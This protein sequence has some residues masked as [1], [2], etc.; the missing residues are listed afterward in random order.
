M[1]TYLVAFFLSAICALVLTPL[2]RDFAVA[3][4]AVDAGTEERKVHSV[5]TPRVGGIAI[6]VAFAVPVFGL[7]F[8][9]NDISKVYLADAPQ[10]IGLAGGALVMVLLGLVDDL[11]GVRPRT[12]LLV[13]VLVATGAYFLGYSIAKIAT[14]F[15][16]PIELGWLSYPVTV[17]WIVGIVN[18]I[19]LIDGLDGLATGI[20]LFTVAILF[21]LGVV[22]HNIIVSTTAI[23]LAGALVGFLRY[24][25]NPASI[26]MG[27]SGSLFLGY[28]LAVTAISGSSKSSTVVSLLIP[29]LAMGVPVMDTLLAIIR[30]FLAGRHLFEA[31]RGHVHHRLLDRG[32]SQRQA[33]LV[34]YAGCAFLAVAALSIMYANSATSAVILGAIAIAALAFSKMIGL[35]SWSD[36][37]HSVRYGLARNQGLRERLNVIE[38][39]AEGMRAAPTPDLAIQCLID[40]MAQLQVDRLVLSADV[41]TGTK[42]HH[43]QAE[44]PPRASTE[45]STLYLREYPLDWTFGDVMVQGRL[46]F[47]WYCSQEQLQIPESGAYDW[48]AMVLRDRFLEVAAGAQTPRFQPRIVQTRPA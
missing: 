38:L 42:L 4:G 13:E 43:F 46:A 27:D 30:R 36:L 5:P 15:G 14:P 6:A 11:R 12:K 17:L 41:H 39:T 19:N 35:L 34:L 48:L 3:R 18:A 9:D 33:V 8:W 16:A 7:F 47:G 31:D 2:A 21:V 44:S 22:H 28:A 20:A 23:A 26:F 32:L 1:L 29:L 40:A 25:F 10:L 37:R 24:N 45:R